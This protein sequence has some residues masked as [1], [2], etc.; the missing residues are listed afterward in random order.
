MSTLFHLISC[1]LRAEVPKP[2][3][4]EL[5]DD[6]RTVHGSAVVG[7]SRHKLVECLIKSG[8]HVVVDGVCSGKSYSLLDMM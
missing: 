8:L 4:Y 6:V 3:T 2:N 1:L 5:T 7:L